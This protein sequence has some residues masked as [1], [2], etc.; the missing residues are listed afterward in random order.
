MVGHVANTGVRRKLDKIVRLERNDI[1]EDIPAL[2]CEV[3]DH[4]V[5]AVT[6]HG[7]ELGRGPDGRWVAEVILDI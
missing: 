6:R 7:L 2:Q 4:E 3:L 5:K 1:G